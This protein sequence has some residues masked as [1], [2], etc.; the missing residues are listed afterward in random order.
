MTLNVVDEHD[1]ARGDDS[2]SDYLGFGS[3][4][5][6]EDSYDRASDYQDT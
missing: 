4:Y 1:E 6:S 2:D 5:D 3:Q